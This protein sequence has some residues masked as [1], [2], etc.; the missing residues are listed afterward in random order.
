MLKQKKTVL[1]YEC[2]KAFKTEDA[3]KSHGAAK[4][5]Q[6][7]TPITSSVGAGSAAA[8]VAK[9]KVGQVP[10]PQ[11]TKTFATEEGLFCHTQVKH[12]GIH[13]MA[14]INCS[15]C[16]CG[17]QSW[18]AWAKASNG[19]CRKHE[20]IINAESPPDST[21]YRHTAPLR[22]RKSD[23]FLASLVHHVGRSSP[24]SSMTAYRSLWSHSSDVCP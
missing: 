6:W 13:A 4:K 12:Q 18:S 5:H 14:G 20:C 19:F 3:C 22:A 17:C 7:Q 11:C 2:K 23:S 16:G 24:K 1:C 10:C 21:T 15:R 9:V 8:V